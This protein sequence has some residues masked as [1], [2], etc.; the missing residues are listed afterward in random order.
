MRSKKATLKQRENP[1]LQDHF[2]KLE[3]RTITIPPGDYQPT[4]AAKESEYDMPDA[5]MKT[6]R[7]A[8]FKPIKM[9]VWDS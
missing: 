3:P 4:K 9:K 1:C 8:F 6:V 5:T 7:N 2:V